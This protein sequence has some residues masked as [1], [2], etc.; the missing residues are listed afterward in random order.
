MSVTSDENKEMLFSLF[1]DIQNENTIK[2]NTT[3]KND[4]HIFISR[5]CEYLHNK[6][7]EFENINEINKKIIDNSY[8]YYNKILEYKKNLLKNQQ[9]QQQQSQNINLSIP[10]SLPDNKK[11]SINKAFQQQKND[12]ES[13]IKPKQDEIDFTEPNKDEPISNLDF[14]M[15]QTLADR[16]KELQAITQQYSQGK[17]AKKWLETTSTQDGEVEKLKIDSN[18]N[19]KLEIKPINKP[20]KKVTF[21]DD[22]P[23]DKFEMASFLSKLKKKKETTKKPNII[24][25]ARVGEKSKVF[26]SSVTQNQIILD[27]LNIIILNQENIFK[28][29]NEIKNRYHQPK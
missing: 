28:Q 8:N 29:L 15:S 7:F 12:F 18:S 24:I 20:K 23:V 13:H 4:L 17:D 19:V 1:D 25:K 21:Q 3:E 14:I 11:E 16:E 9:Q 22:K 27:K 26:E 6:R 5:Q 2:L 10:T